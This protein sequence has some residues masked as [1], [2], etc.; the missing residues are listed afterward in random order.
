MKTL[1]R[2]QN[3]LELHDNRTCWKLDNDISIADDL[4][5]QLVEDACTMFEEDTG[6]EIYGLGRSGRHVCV[7]DTPENSRKYQYLKSKA[8]K[9]EAWVI[10]A[11]NEY[12][13]K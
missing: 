9:L 7:E 8:L 3:Y 10:D 1:P 12:K 5:Y 11:F 4:L 6:V 13:E 2:Y